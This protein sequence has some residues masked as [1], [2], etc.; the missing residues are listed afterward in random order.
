MILSL[1]ALLGSLR[2]WLSGLWAVNF[3]CFL[4]CSCRCGRCLVH[5]ESGYLDGGLSIS[6][7]FVVIL[8]L[9]A[10]FGSLRKWLSRGLVVKTK[11]LNSMFVAAGGVLC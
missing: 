8:S 9:R 4:S 3:R 1:R 11:G 2:K 10:L 7:V 5:F 6:G